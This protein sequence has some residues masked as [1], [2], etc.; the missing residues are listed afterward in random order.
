MK[1]HLAVTTSGPRFDGLLLPQAYLA[2]LERARDYADCTT[3][4]R[5]GRVPLGAAEESSMLRSAA[6]W[7]LT[8]SRRC[9]VQY[10]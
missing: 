5:D 6:N 7:S 2:A 4:I 10:C 8:A 9:G 3:D 1:R